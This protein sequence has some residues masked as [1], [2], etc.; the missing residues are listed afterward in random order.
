MKIF[1]LFLKPQLKKSFKNKNKESRMHSSDSPN[2]VS[3]QM[4]NLHLQEDNERQIPCRYFKWGTCKLGEN[5]RFLHSIKVFLFSKKI[6]VFNKSTKK[7]T[8]KG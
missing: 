4:K 5:C 2:G 7:I 1:F 3:H 8:K 6:K